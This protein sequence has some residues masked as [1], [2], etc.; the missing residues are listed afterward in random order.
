[1]SRLVIFTAG[2][3]GRSFRLLRHAKSFASR[4]LSHVTLIGTDMTSLPKEID[5]APNIDHILFHQ[6]SIPLP[7]FYVFAPIYYLFILLQFLVVIV[8]LPTFDYL[9][10]AT[11][12]GFIDQIFGILGRIVRRCKLIFDVGSYQWARSPDPRAGFFHS[13]EKTLPKFANFRIV[14]TR[15]MQVV[16]E[17]RRLQSSLL[18]DPPGTQFRPNQS[19]RPSACE[20]LSVGAGSL[21][22]AIPV[23]QL[24][25]DKVRQLI[26]VA[27]TIDGIAT[28]QIV[29]VVFGGG[30]VQSSFENELKEQRFRNI[31]YRVFALNTDVYS[32]I[33]SCADLGIV[34]EGSRFGLDVAKEVVEMVASGLPLLAFRWGCVAEYVIDEKSGF[35]F[36]DE[37]GLVE[38][39]K[40]VINA[41]PSDFEGWRQNS[42]S[43]VLEWDATWE[44]VFGEIAAQH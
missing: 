27:R 36:K 1:M 23:P 16:L 12:N 19:I 3:L 17:L 35:F 15:S 20:L 28:K 2:D 18:Y 7:F 37:A 32:Q 44:K 33:L 42:P 6:F 21:L 43:R 14:S 31:V 5:S 26:S 22:V 29:F 41:Q 34:F 39:L 40:L 30:K 11:S 4:E 25:G 13:L 10:I 38:L 8:P 9:L 24:N